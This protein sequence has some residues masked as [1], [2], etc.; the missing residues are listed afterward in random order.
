MRVAAIRAVKEGVFATLEL[1]SEQA[2]LGLD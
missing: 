1:R 2:I